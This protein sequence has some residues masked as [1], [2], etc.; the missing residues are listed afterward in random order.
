MSTPIDHT[1]GWTPGHRDTPVAALA[2]AVAAHPHKVLFDF[3][4][5][6]NHLCCIRCA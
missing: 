6:K 1:P 4:G 5:E 3:S 2:R